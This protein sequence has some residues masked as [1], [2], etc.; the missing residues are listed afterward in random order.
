[1][2]E[3]DIADTQAAAPQIAEAHRALLAEAVGLHRQGKLAE[4]TARYE[5][6]V[7]E[8]PA[9]TD[10]LYLLGTASFQA[11][12]YLH[13]ALWLQ[14]ATAANP[15]SAAAHHLTGLARMKLGMADDA[16]DS[17][18]RAAAIDPGAVQFLAS[19]A[20]AL[21]EIGRFAEAADAYAAVVARAPDMAEAWH[22][23]SHALLQSRKAEA[24]LASV[25]RALAL[26][27]DNL[28]C[29]V[30]RAN[31]LRALGRNDDAVAVYDRLLTRK[32]PPIEAL[33][34]RA[35]TLAAMG[36]AEDAIRACDQAVGAMPFSMDAQ[37]TRG[38]VLASL[39]AAEDALATFDRVLVSTPNHT[40][41]LAM[42]AAALQSLNRFP[43]ALAAYDTALA[44]MP[45]SGK[46]MAGRAATLNALG[47]FDEAF[48]ALDRALA[49]DP[50][51]P[52]VRSVAG[53]IELLHGRWTQGWT[54]Y[55]SRIDVRSALGTTALPALAYPRWTG[56]D[57]D[58]GLLVLVTEQGLGDAIQAARFAPVLAARGHRV[59][60]LTHLTLAPFFGGLRGVE[61]VI[62][63]ES[64]LKDET[65]PVCWLPAMSA[66]RLLGVTD[67]T[68]PHEVPY[69][70]VD[71]SRIA[72]WH[73]K[74]ASRGFKIGI[75]WQGNP[76]YRLDHG[77][78]IPLAAFAPLAD[79]PG[80][81]LIALQKQLG[82]EQ[83]NGVP[84]RQKIELH[85]RPA[86]QRG[87]AL[88]DTAAIMMNLDLVVTSDTMAAHLAGA[89]GRPVFVALRGV[90]DWR[91]LLQ[92]DDSPWYPT[93]RLFRQSKDGNW[94][95]VFAR[96]AAAAR[97]MA[98]GKA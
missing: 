51:E 33:L 53:Q 31:C 55:D 11:E 89:L 47:R 65:A 70:S 81:R 8:D 2:T 74:I 20:N 1:M 63:A 96:I 82:A 45:S 23:Q 15:Q 92:R 60:V 6:V 4:A 79:I 44:A 54:H 25:D 32:P 64:E 80:V 41:A 7:R 46:L 71:K 69:L 43:D 84:F 66:A 67:A 62:I 16:L 36:R 88:F 38:C 78:S 30:L 49:L 12:R 73:E 59:A 98:R 13:A 90:P 28:H 93:M 5:A 48:V 19:R 72:D 42:R 91:W 61:R 27:P 29:D 3:T 76:Q 9:N 14:E 77:R 95:D 50:D 18:D 26:Q 68:V 34:G 83:V 40:M 58:G 10:A 94:S 87:N 57:P 97:D 39:G 85:T 86:D 21:S 17:F 35:M 22:N 24:A 52:E 75:V 37:V 56:E